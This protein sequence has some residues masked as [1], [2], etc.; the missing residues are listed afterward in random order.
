M[1]TKPNY[2]VKNITDD[3]RPLLS[4]QNAQ[5]TAISQTVTLAV[6]TITGAV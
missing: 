5:S 4:S 2:E 3:A 1:E 6:P